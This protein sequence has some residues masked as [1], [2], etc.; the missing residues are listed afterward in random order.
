MSI[1]ILI[2]DKSTAKP[3]K[4]DKEDKAMISAINRERADKLADPDTYWTI[5]PS[6]MEEARR[7]HSLS[8]PL[9]QLIR[10]DYVTTITEE[11]M[12]ALWET[13]LT[14]DALEALSKTDTTM[15][16]GHALIKAHEAYSAIREQ[17]TA[18]GELM[19]KNGGYCAPKN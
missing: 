13:N 2:F 1:E 5:R 12:W 17:M 6:Y 16:P 9:A 18:S 14:M 3:A 7:V 11:G 10:F 4:T 15:S 19:I 8:F